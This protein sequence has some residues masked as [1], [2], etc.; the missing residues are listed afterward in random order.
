MSPSRHFHVRGYSGRVTEAVVEL[1]ELSPPERTRRAILGLLAWWGA[2][3]VCVFIPIAHFVLVPGC[4]IMGL[5]T[6]FRRMTHGTVV[7]SAR[8]TCPDCGA[9]QNLDL[10][11]PFKGLRDIVC[12][13]CQR[14]LT[15]TPADGGA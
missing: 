1:R 7:A 6:L 4:F 3:V 8:A 5:V 9:E 11:G 12:R 10:K 15:V 14:S 2:G 13:S